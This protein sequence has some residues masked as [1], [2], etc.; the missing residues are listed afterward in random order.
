MM[1][2]QSFLLINVS[3]MF[4]V[5]NCISVKVAADLPDLCCNSFTELE[6]SLK[7]QNVNLPSSASATYQC[8]AE[9]IRSVLAEYA[10]VS[11]KWQSIEEEKTKPPFPDYPSGKLSSRCKICR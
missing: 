2:S 1:K 7:G 4:V 3:Q 10:E 9:Q 6:R 8:Q 5:N 11:Q